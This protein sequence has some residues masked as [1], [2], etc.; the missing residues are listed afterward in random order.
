V[1]YFETAL[2]LDV[3]A[4]PAWDGLDYCEQ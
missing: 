2:Q 4:Q 3:W 1:P